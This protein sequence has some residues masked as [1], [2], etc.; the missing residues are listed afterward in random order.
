MQAMSVDEFARKLP[1][2]LD[3]LPNRGGGILVEKEG[4]VFLIEIKS[5]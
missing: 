1:T 3:T 4:V 2:V 5:V